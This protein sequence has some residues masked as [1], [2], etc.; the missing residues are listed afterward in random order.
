MDELL[1]KKTMEK[2]NLKDRKEIE[3]PADATTD[4]LIQSQFALK[5]ANIPFK[6][7]PK[8]STKRKGYFLRLFDENQKPF[9]DFTKG[10]YPNNIGIG[11]VISNDKLL[12]EQFLTYA[13]VK[14]PNTKFF[15]PSEYS[16]AVRYV[17][18]QDGKC[19][20]KPKDL[21]QSLGA[22]RDVDS[23]NIDSA[24]HK[25][26]KIQK[27]Y[28]VKNPLIIIQKQVE[29]LELRITVLE[30]KAD[31]ATLRAPG[32]V[33]G[34]GKSSIKSLIDQKNEI[35]KK[36]NFHFKNPFKLNKILEDSLHNRDL[37]LDSILD[38]DEYL[39]LYPT[40][41]IATGRDNIEISEFIHPNIFRQA[42]DAV[43]AIP[44]VHTAGVDIII[45]NLDAN[46][47]TVLEVNQNP[48]FQ[49]NYFNM[50]GKQQDPL[51]TL[52]SNF[53]LEHKVLN[54]NIKLKDLDQNELDTILERYRFL[55]KKQNILADSIKQIIQEK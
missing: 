16:S 8:K 28:K 9:L 54:E 25:N 11:K 35:R 29:G 52:F 34:D 53:K 50:Y 44:N 55:F 33:V 32:Y 6:K 49:V 2:L 40:V 21:R 36:N 48:A 7:I 23:S 39:I 1:L 42:E 22:F 12:T 38:K 10:F 43:T 47:G 20:L 15:K 4:L 31:T 46:E 14:T 30:G 19:V 41:G 13:G 3:Y 17:N 37:S 5:N 24:W 26:L 27:Q 45:S 51:S 18:S